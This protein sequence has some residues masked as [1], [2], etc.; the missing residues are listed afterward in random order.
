MLT[1]L[2]CAPALASAQQSAFSSSE[3]R[4]L[5]APPAGVIMARDAVVTTTAAVADGV[6]TGKVTDA[7]S[8]E[9]ISSVT[10]TVQGT[11][12]GAVSGNDGT[13][14][15][16]RVP[17]GPHTLTA[18]RVG[19]AALSRRITIPD[20]STVTLDFPLQPSATNLESV[21][22]TGTAGDQLR[23]TQPAV[24][25]AVDVS[26]LL[27]E[28]SV[29]NVTDVL[30]GRVPSLQVVS[31]S[32][33]TGS[34]ARIN[35]RG[36][37]SYSLSN[38]P[39]VFIDGIRMRSSQR[40]LQYVGGQAVNALNDLNPDDIESVEVV[41][42]PAAATLYGAD[43]SAGVIQ[44]ITKKGKLGLK[45]L[46]QSITT[47]YNTIKPNFT[48]TT[49]YAKCTAAS[50][51][52]TSSSAFCSGQALGTI[53]SDNPNV[54]GGTYSDGDLRSLRYNAQGGGDNYG[55]FVS[56]SA[57]DEQG[58]TRNNSLVRRDGRA[59]L[60]WV[61]TPNL[62]VDF[63]LG[64]SKNDYKLPNND[65][66]NY[67]SLIYAALGSVTGVTRDASG[68]LSS[69]FAAGI[70]V[71]AISSIL[72]QNNT[73]RTTP[74]MQLHYTPFAWLANRVTVG[75]DMNNSEGTNFFPVNPFN[76]YSG[77]QANGFVDVIRENANIYTVDYLGTIRTSLFGRANTTSDLSF[78]SQFIRTTFEQVEGTGIGLLTNSANL[79]SSASKVTGAQVYTD[80]KSLGYF[81]QEQV[82]FSDKLYFQ[83]GARL[84]RNSAFGTTS[85]SIFLPKVGASYVISREPFLS[86]YSSFLPTLRLRAAY[87]STGRSPTPGASLRTYAKAPY[88]TDLGII[89]NGVAPRNPGNVN[90]KPERG[91]E[92]EGGFD[93]GLFHDRV[94]VEVTYYKKTTSD[95]LVVNPLPPSLGFTG[96]PLV[97][98]GKVENH[99]LEFVVRARPL[100][101]PNFSWDANFI[102]STLN[103]KVLSLGSSK[104]V[105]T[106]SLGNVS[107]KV[108]VGRAL[109]AWFTRRIQS[110][111]PATGVVVVGDTSE[112]VG[113]VL[114]TL[115]GSFSSTFTVF[116]NISVYALFQ[117]Q[118]GA[119][120]F[121]VGPFYRDQ[122][123]G[124]SPEVILPAGQGGYNARDR[125]LR[126]GPFKT[127]SGGTIGGTQGADGYVQSTDYIRFQELALTLS[128]PNRLA[129]AVRATNA[130]LTLGARNLNLWTRFQ[131]PDPDVNVL[132][133]SNGGIA[134][135]LQ[136]ELFTAPPSR[137]FIARFNLQF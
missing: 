43:A 76:W 65:Q 19:Y 68:K 111:D 126:L 71:D 86:K 2:A 53:V 117:G 15:L 79:V 66:G 35:I 67:G 34:T 17:A 52:P 39:I 40:D 134:Q 108:T 59:S 25:S 48:P 37:V 28:T 21:V 115:Q 69:G 23:E 93:A 16:A 87:G 62:G 6:V 61:A 44:I 4:D 104:E 13:Y 36:A 26:D 125:A 77:D 63:S 56:G 103:N 50:I 90:L 124:N 136:A 97:N 129:Q 137:R 82:G 3:S 88:I 110:Y 47:E 60:N 45:R 80:Q 116:K 119:K 100:D 24:V 130:S 102:A 14:R 31:G 118:R 30:R 135:F 7:K 20:G 27:K 101:R 99:G 72:N 85:S 29:T 96:S 12:L 121:N 10:V 32:G 42:G 22:V 94:G 107:N 114:P 33:M 74:S 78:G 133:T 83:L 106:T 1:T 120:A 92:F 98:I 64:L 51:L 113:N 54:R 89:V 75:A 11:Q 38:D 109:G 91:T 18:R 57:D 49:N 70:N 41:K 122:F 81:A 8:G 73:I 9:P 46:N 95:L 112:F 58:T 132:N 55:F 123:L 128:L 131:G 84:D 5:G 127:L 105:V